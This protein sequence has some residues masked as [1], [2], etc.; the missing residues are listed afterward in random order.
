MLFMQ[1]AVQKL[2]RKT[3]I[4]MLRG[5]GKDI[6]Y[7]CYGLGGKLLHFRVPMTAE[8][9]AGLPD[10]WCAIPA[11]QIAGGDNVEEPRER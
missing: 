2:A 11:T 1:G 9:Y 6:Q 3:A 10:A 4:R 8:E 7:I 5:V